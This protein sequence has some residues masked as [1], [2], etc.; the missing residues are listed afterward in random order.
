MGIGTRPRRWIRLGMLLALLAIALPA[1][2]G[3]AGA[4]DPAGQKVLR[5]R[6]PF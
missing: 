6:M 4:Q 5:V 2:G 3:A 1:L